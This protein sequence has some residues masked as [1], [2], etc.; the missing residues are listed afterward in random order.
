MLFQIIS[1]TPVWVWAL[2]ALL[3]WL[4]LQ[5][6]MPGRVTLRR[7][8]VMPIAMTVMSLFGTLNAF[9]SHL[10]VLVTWLTCAALMAV[11]VLQ[12][13]L[14][15]GTRFDVRSRYFDVQGSWVPLALMMGIFANK[16]VVGVALSMH[17]ELALNTVFSLAFSALY[18]AFSGVFVARAVRLWSLALPQLRGATVSAT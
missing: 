11:I 4:G 18:G 6:I 15:A 12:S 8:T 9:G 1:H 10:E 13:P 14:P 16:Y 5:Q 7:I 17:P 3:L 2:F